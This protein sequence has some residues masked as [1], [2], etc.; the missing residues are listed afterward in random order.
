LAPVETHF[1]VREIASKSLSL[2]LLSVLERRAG[3]STYDATIA[4]TTRTNERLC[5]RV[6]RQRLA[7]VSHR[8]Q[9]RNGAETA[10]ANTIGAC[11]GTISGH[12]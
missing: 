4:R 8:G 9:L 3:Q 1:K 7:A 10:P 5:Q 2:A 11:L 12:L 6:S